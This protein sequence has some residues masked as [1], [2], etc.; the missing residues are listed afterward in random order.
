MC[1]W[2]RVPR[3][4]HFQFSFASKR[5]EVIQLFFNGAIFIG[6]RNEQ[7]Q[8]TCCRH[9]TLAP[10]LLHFLQLLR[11]LSPH[12]EPSCHLGKDDEHSVCW[13][14]HPSFNALASEKM[15]WFNGSSSSSRHHVSSRPSY[16][17]SSSSVFSRA[18]S[19]YS[20]SGSSYY[21]RRSRDGYIERL[22]HKLKQ[23]FR[24]L[25]YYARRNPAKLFFLVVMPL[26]S[27]GVLTS[28]ARQLGVRLPSFL[29]GAQAGM[30]G[31]GGYYGSQGYGTESSG[32]LGGSMGSLLNIAKAFI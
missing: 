21:K 28:V 9:C 1:D 22:L 31:G 25:Y 32:G 23:L 10:N 19:S 3:S 18:S 8:Y 14:P 16:H 29:Q 13:S 2:L 27:G 7:Q 17:R 5:G 15:G 24:E 4:S 26:I 20:R 11:P 6:L 12:T 30:G